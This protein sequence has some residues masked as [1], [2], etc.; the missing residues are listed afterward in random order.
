M[1]GIISDI[2]V[3][4]RTRTVD[5][6]GD[7]LPSS[8]AARYYNFPMFRVNGLE[9]PAASAAI[10]PFRGRAHEGCNKTDQAHDE[11]AGQLD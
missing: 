11:K 3:A 4:N 9:R 1:G 2:S 6:A 8:E 10:L 7:M 5:T